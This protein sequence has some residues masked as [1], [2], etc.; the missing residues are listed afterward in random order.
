MSRETGSYPSVVTVLI[1]TYN[2]E[3]Y[4]GEAVKSVFAN[5]DDLEQHGIGTHIEIV[6]MD[7]GSV[8]G[9]RQVVEDF[10]DL[11]PA[12]V[13]VKYQYQENSGQ[14]AAYQNSLPLITGEYVCLLDSDD[15]FLPQKIRKVL[16]VFLRE[17]EVGLLGHPLYVINSAGEGEGEVRPKAA[18][19]SHGDI[20]KSILKNG[21]NVAPPTSGLTFR[22][23]V[24][25]EIHPSPLYGLPSA[26]DA[27]L[28]I[29]ASLKANVF[30][31]DEPLA[32]YRQHNGSQYVKR[33]TSISGL[34]RT[35]ATQSK[36]L[37]HLKLEKTLANN[38]YFMRHKFVLVRM[39]EPF[40]KW[41][42]Q[43]ALFNA[44][45]LKDPFL[46][47]KHKVA[48]LLFW[49]AIAFLPKSTFWKMWIFFQM[50]H[51]GNR[52][53]SSLS[54]NQPATAASK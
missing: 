30:A 45:L 20:K 14:A 38:S 24:F 51:T 16:E 3:A 4:I 1:A 26:A 22:R 54:N 47:F 44:A 33:L 7:D 23:E 36:I 37:T 21:R 34:Q 5:A 53:L 2:H 10:I 11:N 49:N 50:K 28:S 9:T 13:T 32:E 31:M 27:Y 42:K 35:M 29:S 17:K 15:R 48:F 6:V 18:K 46:G 8:D 52:E 40:A 12:K 19:I 39:E 43:L 41:L 25:F